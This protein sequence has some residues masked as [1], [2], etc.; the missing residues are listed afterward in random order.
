MLNGVQGKGGPRRN[1]GEERSLKAKVM[2][3]K[4]IEKVQSNKQIK[5]A[6]Q[7][8]YLWDGL[9]YFYIME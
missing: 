1:V 7:K 5:G 4:S 6:P 2:E 3:C 9:I 8:F